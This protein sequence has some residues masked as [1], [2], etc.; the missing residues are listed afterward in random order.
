MRG[1]IKKEK[2]KKEKE[3]YKDTALIGHKYW[4]LSPGEYDK[5]SAK[6]YK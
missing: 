3:T 6:A 5:P 2:E 1:E 4:S